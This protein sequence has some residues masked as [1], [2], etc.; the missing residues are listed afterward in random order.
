MSRACEFKP[1]PEGKETEDKDKGN[2]K[3]EILRLTGMSLVA[4]FVGFFQLL[5]PI[6]IG[7]ILI[8]L[9]VIVG[10][11]PIFKESLYAL[12]KGR[13]NMELSMVIAIIASLG[14]QQFLPA[15]VITFFAL[16]SGFIEEIIVNRGRR[17]IQS[18]Y[19][20]A[21]RKAIVKS[22]D[23]I[24]SYTV[25]IEDVK[26]GDVVII[27]EG[28][29][30]PV[31][32]KVIKGVSLV[33][34]SSITGESTPSEKCIGDFVFAGT[35][36]QTQELEVNCGKLSN[37]TTFSKII[38]LVEG[39][40]GSKAKIGKLSDKMATRL[41]QFAIGLSALTFIITQ[42]VV[43]SLSVIVVA[44]AC[45]L[46]IGTPIAFLATTGKLSKKG[47]IVKGGLQIEKLKNAGT[48][49]FDKTGTL[50]YGDPVVSQVIS[51]DSTIDS[52]RVLE[53]AAIVE[54]NV[55]HPLAGAIIEKASQEKIV[56]N[57]KE[58][59]Q[60]NNSSTV[61]GRGIT[62]MYN[63]Q[64]I[65]IGNNRFVYNEASSDADKPI[66]DKAGISID[67]DG[68]R[69]LIKELR[70]IPYNTIE[71]NEHGNI[72]L[73]SDSTTSFV[74]VDRKIIGAILFEDAIR[75]DAK[76]TM[77]QIKNM[78]I[79][80]IMLTGDNEKIASK[81]AGKLG[82]DEYYSNLLPDEKVTRIEEIL[83]KKNSQMRKEKTV[84]MVGDGINDAPALARADVGIAMG[85]TGTDVAIETADVVLMTDDLSTI[86][87]LIK[88]SRHS[89]FAIQQNFFGTL[90]IDGLGFILAA[91]GHLNPLLAALV[92]IVSELVFMG[93]SARLA[94]D[95]RW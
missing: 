29:I 4:L 63:R 93:N 42:N 86:P 87:Y 28:D 51:F 64:R 48:V 85:K 9:T 40:E 60:I 2:K 35:L 70:S 52:R 57:S 90:F 88:S 34:Q 68:Y 72:N 56:I 27:R 95:R 38:Q 78:G 11:Y 55:N 25:N 67:S 8:F 17:N 75:K 79:K 66:T 5:Q 23:N 92:H 16:L 37:D 22:H 77:S 31:D 36:N 21:P 58:L 59:S 71:N 61:E 54:N 19:E 73:A 12:T 94:F 53:Y 26:I 65:S 84:L 7:N 13:V 49:V 44:G 33:D 15:I 24:Q 47:I 41:I 83:K 10:G 81:V 45:G 89:I 1:R 32:G 50:T 20:L 62:R 3:L 76:S 91:T 30:V 80:T 39:A 74:I 82:I 43:S 14:L 6:W 46:A 18:L 69:H